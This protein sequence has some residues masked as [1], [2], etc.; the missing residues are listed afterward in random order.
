MAVTE[1]ATI[2]LS[3]DANVRE[4]G[5]EAAKIWQDMLTTISQQ[6][7]CQDVF[8]GLQH[9]SP[10]TAQLFIGRLEVTQSASREEYG[11]LT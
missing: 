5:T 2:P 9:E 8:S 3:A 1:I 4:Q 10:S 7:G 11:P 6:D